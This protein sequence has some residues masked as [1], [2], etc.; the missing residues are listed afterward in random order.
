MVSEKRRNM[1]KLFE[2]QTKKGLTF[3]SSAG[4]IIKYKCNNCDYEF[5][6]NSMN[7]SI[8]MC[9]LCGNLT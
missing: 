1:P 7:K 6:K 5:T 4:T 8:L 9:P 3:L 2:E